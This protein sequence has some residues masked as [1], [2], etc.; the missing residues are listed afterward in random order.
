MLSMKRWAHAPLERSYP[1]MVRWVDSTARLALEG[2]S[3][4]RASVAPQP[5]ERY[6]VDTGRH[7][8]GAAGAGG[9][10]RRHR[11]CHG[12]GD[13]T[14]GQPPV[15]VATAYF[16]HSSRLLAEI[17]TVLGRT[18]DSAR[19]LQP[20]G[21]RTQRHALGEQLHETLPAKDLGRL[22]GI[23]RMDTRA[24]NTG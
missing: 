19:F 22:F 24:P 9:G 11:K 8:G 5:H 2:R 6:S 4:A 16:E 10:G 23:R 14:G 15:S 21:S 3:P 1:S 17:A 7:S 13:C 20:S 12:T 18:N